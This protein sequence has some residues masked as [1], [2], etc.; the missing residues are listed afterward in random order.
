M[1][2]PK[3][4]YDADLVTVKLEPSFEVFPDS[5]HAAPR[6]SEDIKLEDCCV[7]LERIAASAFA[8]KD[9]DQAGPLNKARGSRNAMSVKN[10]A[11]TKKEYPCLICHKVLT[12]KAV[13][14]THVYIHTGERPYSC[15]ICKKGF[16]HISNL[17]V[18]E[19]THTG[20]RRYSCQI[21]HKKFSCRSNLNDHV[22]KCK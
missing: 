17:K 15:L 12:S 13:L 14:K 6:H 11:F 2:L 3:E 19:F 7:R 18:H 1:D 16:T 9:D 20:E 22:Y 8:G 10:T 4:L 5:G 21:C